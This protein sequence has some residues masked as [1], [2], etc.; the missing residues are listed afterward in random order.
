MSKRDSTR[1]S[2][3]LAEGGEKVVLL[4]KYRVLR[5]KVTAQIRKENI[6]FNNNR[7]EATDNKGEL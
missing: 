1:K 6:D 2:I 3:R 4:Q 5:N 7:L